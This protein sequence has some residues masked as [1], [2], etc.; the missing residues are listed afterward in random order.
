MSLFV[1]D[2]GELTLASSSSALELTIISAA[3][4]DASAGP[5]H[6]R[7]RSISIHSLMAAPAD[8]PL[9]RASRLMRFTITLMI[10]ENIAGRTDAQVLLCKF[11]RG[12]K[13]AQVSVA[14]I[15]FCSL[16]STDIDV[17]SSGI[18]SILYRVMSK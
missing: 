11:V 13:N 2:L 17:L 3:T 16:N 6:A 5:N 15:C 14:M 4:L 18:N 9:I 10:H 1:L 12:L 8:K 7:D